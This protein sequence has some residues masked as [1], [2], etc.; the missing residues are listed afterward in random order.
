[1]SETVVLVMGKQP[2]AVRRPLRLC[3]AARVVPRLR[4]CLPSYEDRRV[5]RSRKLAQLVI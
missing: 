3:A 2:R 5:V 4:R 1:V